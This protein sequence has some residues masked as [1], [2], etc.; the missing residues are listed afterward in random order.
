MVFTVGANSPDCKPI[1]YNSVWENWPQKELAIT[2]RCDNVSVIIVRVQSSIIEMPVAFNLSIQ[3]TKLAWTALRA[4]LEW[5][6]D[7][8]AFLSSSLKQW[9]GAKIALAK[10]KEP[11]ANLTVT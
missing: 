11:E 7:V 6:T 1:V 10:I 3:P 5:P 9:A 8:L 2:W 4:S